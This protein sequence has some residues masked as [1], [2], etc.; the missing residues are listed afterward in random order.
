M[1]H[2]IL[3]GAR[4]GKSRFG[5]QVVEALAL[6]Q[7]KDNNTAVIN[8]TYIATATAIDGEMSQRILKHQKDRHDNQN[9]EWNLIECPLDLVGIINH[10]HESSTAQGQMAGNVYFIDCM[11]LWL[12]NV[13]YRLEK[14]Q[15]TQKIKGAS[16]N[17]ETIENV[18]EYLNHCVDEL[19]DAL[20]HSQKCIQKKSLSHSHGGSQDELQNQAQEFTPPTFVIISNEVGLGIIPMGESTRLFVDHCGW[21]NQKLA[22]L[23]NEVTLVTAGIPMT[24]KA[25]VIEKSHTC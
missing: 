23:A 7:A 24:I 15:A 2:F 3:G 5:E 6:A 1:I 8:P 11:T 21:L 20:I 10:A 25:A 4:S 14:L 12:N 19:V 9:I 17:I 13:L 22:A 16:D 18:D